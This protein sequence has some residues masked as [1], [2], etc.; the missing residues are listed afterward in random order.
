MRRTGVVLLSGITLSAACAPTPDADCPA[1]TVTEEGQCVLRS[2][3][4][5][6]VAVG[7]P[8]A[9]AVQ[10]AMGRSGEVLLAWT[11]TDTE[12]STLMLAHPDSTSTDGWSVT[13]APGRGGQAMEPA[14]AVDHE[15]RAMVA[16]QEQGAEPLVYLATRDTAG[17]WSW[18]QLPLYAVPQSYEPRVHFGTDG[19]A[20]VVWNQ[21]E[22][23]NLGVAV[24][25]RAPGDPE[26][27]FVG[28]QG[29][30]DLLSP[31]VNFAN[32]PRLAVDEQGRALIAWYQAPVDDLMVFISE[33]PTLDAAFSQ[34]GV[35][36]FISAPGGPVDSHAEANPQPALHSSG[37]A[38]VI[39]TQQTGSDA[40]AVFLATRDPDG[41]WQRP[42]TL[43]ESLSAAGVVARC[44]QL[45]FAPD[46]SLFAT[47]YETDGDRTE[48]MLWHHPR[49]GS[50]PE[51]PVPL[52]SAGARA[53]HP[54]LA[55]TAD[56]DAILAWAE[57]TDEALTWQVRARLFQAAEDR[58]LPAQALGDAAP[59]QDPRPQVVLGPEDRA[60][61]SWTEGS[62]VDARVRVTELR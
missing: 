21:W 27:A 3:P 36:D 52:S 56:G 10:A 20:L 17:G 11:Q 2:W 40:I 32:A 4:T 55:L 33:R 35:T 25:R 62:V 57:S 58:W 24:A 41:A 46:G 14:V 51:A 9:L 12:G 60:L 19:E 45:A 18:P 59:G 44:P 39:W 30:G 50:T 37:A 29:A 28:P 61:V 48:V 53:V 54:A 43:S 16:W 8:G 31:P 23:M 38:A 47:W 22:D 49:D 6:P 5:E 26:G 13:A 42:A 15:G 7:D 1:W 34:P